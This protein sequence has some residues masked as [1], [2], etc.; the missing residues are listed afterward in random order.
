[1]DIVARIDHALQQALTSHSGVDG[2]PRLMA[3]IRHAVFPG[4]ARIRP[5]LTVAVASA[6]GDDTPALTDAAAAAIE[7]LH[8]ASLVHDDLPCFDDAPMRRGQAAVH[9]A[10]G[11]R[12]AVLGGDALIVLAFQV[13]AEAAAAAPLRAATVLSTLARGVG[14]PS[15]AKAVSLNLTVT[16]ATAPGFIT[17]WPCGDRPLASTANYGAGDAVSNGA[18]L[19]LS[20]TGALCIYSNQAVH[21]ILDVNGWWS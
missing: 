19:P 3:A 20:S 16:G 5:R 18:Q 17:A 1:M 10:Y 11:E 7:L 8:C 21:V 12:L 13:V 9:V 14:V 2:P 6:C 4:G 15:S